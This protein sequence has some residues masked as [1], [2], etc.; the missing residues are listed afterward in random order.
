M[1]EIAGIPSAS[2]GEVWDV[3]APLL[4]PA[5]ARSRGRMSV[6]ALR[7]LVEA[8]DAQLWVAREGDGILGAWTTR[9]VTYH[10]G[11]K[12]CEIV[13]CGGSAIERWMIPGLNMLEAWAKAQGCD[14]MEAIGRHGWERMLEPYGYRREYIVLEKEL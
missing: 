10:A 5:V 1:V 6:D 4:A 2:A 13:F 14:R 11:A 9:I 12:V 8:Q 3:V 7:A